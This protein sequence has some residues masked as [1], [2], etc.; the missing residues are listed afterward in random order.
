M[1]WS[2]W[3]N[4][5]KITKGIRKRIIDNI[6]GMK[7]KEHIGRTNEITMQAVENID[8]DGIKRAAKSLTTSRKI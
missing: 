2:L 3:I 5:E 8:W 1:Y 4:N 7:V 6:Q